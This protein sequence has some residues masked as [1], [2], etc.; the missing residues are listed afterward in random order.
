[1]GGSDA[2]A[3]LTF[4]EE[5]H[6]EAA[7]VA[8]VGRTRRAGG[9]ALVFDGASPAVALRGV[10]NSCR[11]RLRCGGRG[12]CWRA[13]AFVA[14]AGGLDHR[15]MLRERTAA[16]STSHRIAEHERPERHDS[17]HR[18]KH[19][20]QFAVRS[21]AVCFSIRLTFAHLRRAPSC[22]SSSGCPRGPHP[23]CRRHSADF[24]WSRC[25]RG[26]PWRPEQL[27][28]KAP[29]WAGSPADA[30]RTDSS[31]Q[32]IASHRR[33]RK[34]GTPRFEAPH[35]AQHTVC[36]EE[37]CWLFPHSINVRSPSPRSHMPEQQRLPSS[38]APGVPAAQR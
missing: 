29:L 14:I 23:A 19:N 6:A 15:L 28:R 10:R 11:A 17:K 2:K 22:R 1:M 34:T 26:T 12:S 37:R 20:A 38:V 30:E 18:T 24:R 13:I 9:T 25:G 4:A 5:P 7:A 36:C 8:L 35:K 32:H 21:A 31:L 3:E 16:C 27:P 33:A